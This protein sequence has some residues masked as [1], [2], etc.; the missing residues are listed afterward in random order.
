MPQ[1][2]AARGAL[3]KVLKQRA[4][5]LKEDAAKTAQDAR[6]LEEEVCHVPPRDSSY[7]TLK[8]DSLD[9]CASYAIRG[10]VW[11]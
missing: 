2:A 10:V 6:D 1:S 4:E 11:S 3:A 9:L 7:P 5:C 8:N